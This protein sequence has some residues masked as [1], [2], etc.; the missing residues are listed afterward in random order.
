MLLNEGTQ[1]GKRDAI[2][3][4]FNLCI[5]H[6]NKIMAV[7]AGVVPV[8]L[9]FLRDPHGVLKDEV[10]DILALLSTHPEGAMAIGKADAVP[11]LVEVIKSGSPRMKENATAVLGEFCSSDRKYLLEAEKL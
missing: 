3:E 8:L 4:L 10:S 2:T 6:G 9:E 1:R 5:Y 11:V 7:R